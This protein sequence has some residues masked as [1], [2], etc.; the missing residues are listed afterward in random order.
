MNANLF[1]ETLLSFFPSNIFHLVTLFTSRLL[2]LTVLN[3]FPF[4]PLATAVSTHSSPL[5]LFVSFA[6]TLSVLFNLIDQSSWFFPFLGTQ[7]AFRVKKKIDSKI[8]FIYIV[9]IGQ[10]S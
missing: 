7:R 3:T 5:F 1:S 9:A 10:L 2:S 8:P 4:C 6:F